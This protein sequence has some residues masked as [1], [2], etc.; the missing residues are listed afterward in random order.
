M[1]VKDSAKMR[2][3]LWGLLVIAALSALF[4]SKFYNAEK[5]ELTDA[6][7]S[8][9]E[10]EKA[11]TL[12]KRQE[13][14][15]QALSLYMNLEEEYAPTHGDGKLYYNI[16]NTYFQLQEYPRAL[17][18]HPETKKQLQPLRQRKVIIKEK[19]RCKWRSSGLLFQIKL[20]FCC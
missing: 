1:L 20:I 6:D 8:Y 2:L 15:N 4:V 11:T 5:K 14:F 3:L 7:S 19:N 18:Y 13:K 10:G 16:G 12:A 9:I 17:L